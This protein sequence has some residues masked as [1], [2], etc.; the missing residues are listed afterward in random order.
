MASAYGSIGVRMG[1]LNELRRVK[2]EWEARARRSFRWGDFLMMLVTLNDSSSVRYE[3]VQFPVVE[4]GQDDPASIGEQPPEEGLESEGFPGLPI[5]LARE[6][7][8][9]IAGLVADKVEAIM[10]RVQ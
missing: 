1:Q 3:A 8:E 9:R 2:A 7:Q 5:T 10:R 4:M 6:D